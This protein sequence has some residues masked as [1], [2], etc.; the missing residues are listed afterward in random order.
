MK[1]KSLSLLSCQV[2]LL[3]TPL[4]H[5]AG[6][7]LPSCFSG[8]QSKIC[9]GSPAR[10]SF[11]LAGLWKCQQRNCV[12]LT[13]S[14]CPHKLM[15]ELEEWK[16]KL[17]PMV[18]IMRWANFCLFHTYWNRHIPALQSMI[19]VNVWVLFSLTSLKPVDM[20]CGDPGFN[21]F[22]LAFG[23]SLLWSLMPGL[24]ALLA[25]LWSFQ[26]LNSFTGTLGWSF[27]NIMWINQMNYSD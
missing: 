16:N 23:V 14:K 10:L 26:Q 17:P 6:I 11:S 27:H 25:G 7:H 12:N 8:T 15:Y 20:C 19:A 2:Y 1:T 5:F 24:A 18:N 13:S 9:A 3:S 21:P 4:A 22:Q